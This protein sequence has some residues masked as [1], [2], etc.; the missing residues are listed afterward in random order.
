MGII[1]LISAI[2]IT[3]QSTF[4]QTILLNDTAYSLA[5]S[6]R[7]AQS[8]GLSSRKFAGVQNGGYGIYV[9]DTNPT[10]SYTIFADVSTLTSAPSWCTAMASTTP[11]SKAGN[12]LYDGV[13]ETFQTYSLTRGFTIG[14]FCGKT[15]SGLQCASTD[16]ISALH[17]VFLRPNTS[18][19]LTGITPGGS[20]VQFSCVH[21]S[22]RAPGG[23]A[24]QT[25]RISQIGEISVGQVCS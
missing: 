12:C 13:G 25:V 23:T 6:T 2:A 9:T 1:F 20:R 19:I 3:G 22:V 18:S 4:N 11:E 21:M 14:D 16:D 10:T 7:Q 24:V 5:L 15:S 17:A 8:L